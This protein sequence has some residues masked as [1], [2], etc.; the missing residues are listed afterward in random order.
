MIFPRNAAHD[1]KPG[2]NASGKQ[3]KQSAP[4][5]PGT[6]EKDTDQAQKHTQRQTEKQI[7]RGVSAA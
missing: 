3:E 5:M 7:R 2:K 6:D 4:D 1:V